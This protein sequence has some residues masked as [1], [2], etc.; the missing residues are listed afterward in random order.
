MAA[1][2]LDSFKKQ[3]SASAILLTRGAMETSAALWYMHEKMKTAT[4]RGELGDIDDTLMKLSVGWKKNS[5]M[6]QAIN[7]LTFMK[8]VEKT[9][10][11]LE[12]QY[13]VLSEFAHP[14]YSGTTRL[15]CKFDRESVM[16]YFGINPRE[17]DSPRIIGLAN[18]SIAVM[19]FQRC[20]HKIDEAMPAFIHLC[21]ASLKSSNKKSKD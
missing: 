19:M 18:L 8:C 11:G 21:E 12:Q 20:F 6:P 16:A 1:D 17:S 10:E 4:G 13:D 9:L 3:K 15:Y 5:D 2:A 7:V 14:N